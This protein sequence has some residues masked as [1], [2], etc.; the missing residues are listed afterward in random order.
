M[1]GMREQVAFGGGTDV[2]AAARLLRKADRNDEVRSDPGRLSVQRLPERL[3]PWQ[4]PTLLAPH[5]YLYWS[6]HGA[7]FRI[8]IL[9][10]TRLEGPRADRVFRP[11]PVFQFHG[12]A[13]GE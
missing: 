12:A 6:R 13:W 11:Q 7:D 3:G 2:D 9:I 10:H 5:L 1:A 4:P 8:V